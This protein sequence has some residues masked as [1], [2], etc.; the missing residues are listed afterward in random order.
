MCIYDE[1]VD[2]LV[3]FFLNTQFARINFPGARTTLYVGE[4]EQDELQKLSLIF[5]PTMAG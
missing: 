4:R 5:R 1:K 2:V 3:M